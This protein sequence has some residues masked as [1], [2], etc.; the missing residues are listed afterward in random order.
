MNLQKRSALYYLTENGRCPF[1]EWLA[2]LKD[3]QGKAI[4]RARIRRMELGNPGQYR[5][6]DNGVLELKI[7]FGPGYRIYFGEDG[8]E[9]IVLLCGGDKSTQE[10][11]IRKAQEF[12]D[13]YRRSK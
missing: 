13:D 8:K 6:I 12:W 5:W 2:N 9:I 1:E 11:D 3:V 10:R 7:N 4:I